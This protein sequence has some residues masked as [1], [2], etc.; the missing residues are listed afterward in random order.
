MD[1]QPGPNLRFLLGFAR[2]ATFVGLFVTVISMTG[3]FRAIQQAKGGHVRA[4]AEAVAL[5]LFGTVAGLVCA[6][7]LV[8]APVLSLFFFKDW[9]R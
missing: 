8:F 3:R 4:P 5:A 6:V 1:D 7:P 9:R 2:F